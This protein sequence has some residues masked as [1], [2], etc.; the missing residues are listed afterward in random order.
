MLQT[1][2]DVWIKENLNDL[3]IGLLFV[4]VG[5]FCIFLGNFIHKKYQG[6]GYKIFRPFKRE[7]K[8]QEENNFF[9]I[10]Y[11]HKI[12]MKTILIFLIPFLYG[13]NK[14]GII[15]NSKTENDTIINP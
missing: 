13:C 4:F 1:K 8:T 3:G 6:Q 15:I 12:I 9:V 2:F 11:N 14:S 7:G 5:L 10:N